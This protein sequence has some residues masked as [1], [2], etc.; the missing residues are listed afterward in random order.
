MSNEVS[1]TQ[2]EF[3]F[4]AEMKQLLHLIIHSLYTHPEVF[5]RELVSNSSDA[6][7]KVRIKKLTDSEIISPDTE[8]RINIMINKEQQTFSIEDFGIGMTK[9]ELI[10]NLGVVASSGT[11]NFLK[12]AKESGKPI[13]ANLIGQFGVGFYSVFM[14]TDEVVVETRSSEPFSKSYKW[15]SNGEASYTIE[16]SERDTR[17]TKISFKFKDE[18]SDFADEFRIK[19]I[20]TKYSNFVEFPIYVNNEKANKVEALW[21]KKKDDINDEELT[22]FYK[23]ISNDYQDPLGHLHL[24]IEGNINFKALLFIPSV[25]P[26]TLFRDFNEKSVQLY[27]NK[28]FIQ[29]NAIDLIPEYLRFLR[30]VVDTEDLPLNVSREVTQNSPIMA[31]IRNVIT[32]K[33]LS[34]LDEWADK[35]KEKYNKFF[36]QFGALFKT[37]LNS[38]FTNKDKITELLRFETSEFPEGELRSLNS[39]VASMKPDQKDI[40]YATGNTREQLEKNPNLEYFKKN[41]LEVIYFTDPVDLFVMPYLFEYDGKKVVSIEKAEIDI[42][43][44]DTKQTDTIGKD[45]ANSLV[46]EFKKVLGDK[47]EDVIISKRLVDSP[48]SVVLG[49]EGF[50]PQMEK[51]MKMMDKDFKASRRVLEINPSHQLIKNL[52]KLHIAG[53]NSELLSKSIQQIFEGSMLIDGNLENPVDFVKRM[54]EILTITT[55]Q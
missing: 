39:Y 44:D 24:N 30:G 45:A 33:T 31:K 22:E 19:N 17:G 27:S 38:D 50:D 47:V 28:I 49:K 37:G 26:A 1:A 14:V 4:K 42:K 18:Y 53:N 23:F 55:N 41:N 35:E 46:D 52:S 2:Q 12:S 40:Y 10:N 3:E 54:S 7:N 9:E 5:L 29:D 34:M 36:I 51:M 8:L 43:E 20:L 32:S 25:A 6:M 21:H 16:E 15:T 13:D 48:A 11:L